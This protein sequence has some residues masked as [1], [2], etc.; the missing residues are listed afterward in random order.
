M[1]KNI[2]ENSNTDLALQNRHLIPPI[3]YKN[4][5]YIISNPKLFLVLYKIGKLADFMDFSEKQG[6]DET[7][8]WLK[9]KNLLNEYF[10]EN[11]SSCY[12]SCKIKYTSK[13]R[14]FAKTPLRFPTK[15][16]LN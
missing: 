2:F 13:M 15:Y 12:V 10:L 1:D 16:E 7:K 6:Y 3:F 8:N 11:I 5:I 4:K 14:F 9:S